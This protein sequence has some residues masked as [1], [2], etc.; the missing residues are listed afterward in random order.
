V[1]RAIVALID[2]QGIESAAAE[3]ATRAVLFY[4]WEGM[5][6]G[7][8]AEAAFAESY[9]L[10][11]TDSHL[12]PYLQLFLAHRWK[13]ARETLML[14]KNRPQALL[15]QSKYKSQITLLRGDVDPLVRAI[16]EDL[17]NEPALYIDTQKLL[18]AESLFF[19]LA[20]DGNGEAT[21]SI[22]FMPIQKALD[23]AAKMIGERKLNVN[24]QFIHSVSL[25]YEDGKMLYPDG[26]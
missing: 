20:S 8:L 15:I 19:P 7:P 12:R 2:R 3:Y 24:G 21:P 4:E 23:L 13:C 10:E 9:L 26:K 14:E 5:S 18:T 25:G 16:A 6:E 1:E 11:K 22:P 17:D